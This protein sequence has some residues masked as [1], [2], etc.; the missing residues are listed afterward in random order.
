MTLRELLVQRQSALCQRW[1][2][3]VLDDHGGGAALWR[4]ERDPFANPVGHT[5]AA[6]LPK[7]IEAVIGEG[8]PD[9]GAAALEAIVRIRAVQVLAPS[10]AVAFILCLRD[11]V[12]A[13]LARELVGGTFAAELE[14]L[15]RR[16][17]R[18]TLL[19]F[20]GYVRCREQLFHLRI[21]ELKRSVATLLRRWNGEEPSGQAAAEALPRPGM[22][23]SPT[24]LPI[25]H[26]GD[27]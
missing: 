16:I 11:A 18:L 7:L 14:A 10:R 19:A 20:D 24:T 2:G 15:D 12:R 8:E 9:A 21:D 17:E 25:C 27:R 22:G 5:L 1:L 13:E 6:E 26:S 4:R 3:A 23:S